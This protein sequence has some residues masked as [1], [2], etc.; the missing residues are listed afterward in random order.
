MVLMN[1]NVDYV[2]IKCVGNY[3]GKITLLVSVRELMK[4]RVK[5]I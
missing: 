3:L 1:V 2:Y 4:V 5:L